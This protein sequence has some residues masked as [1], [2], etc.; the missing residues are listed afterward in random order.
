ME[1]SRRALLG[2]L[3]AAA[4]AGAGLPAQSGRI[5]QAGSAQLTLASSGGIQGLRFDDAELVA[6]GLGDGCPELVI[7]GVRLR[8]DAP[9][10]ERQTATGIA[11]EYRFTQ[12]LPVVVTYD[13]GLRPL[14]G[15]TAVLTQKVSFEV[16]RDYTDRIELRVPRNLRLPAAQRRDFAPTREGV[17]RR[18]EIPERSA[19]A[20]EY[21]MAGDGAADGAPRLG[22][23]LLGEY[24]D[25]TTVRLTACSEPAF[26]TTFRNASASEPG[27]FG[28]THTIGGRRGERIERTF[29]SIVGRLAERDAVLSIYDTA[30]A[31]V[32]PGPTWLRDVTLV[33]YDYLSENGRGW[34]A[35][36]DALC[37]WFPPEARHRVVVT[38]HGWFDFV[39]RYAFDPVRKALDKRWVAF[40]HAAHPDFI[41]HATGPMSKTA[42]FWGW[43]KTLAN[44]R[45]VEMSLDDM[46]RRI[47]YA[48]DRGIRCVLYFGD[49]VNSGDGLT[50]IHD[51]SKVLAWGGWIGPETSGRTYSQNPL[52]PGVRA[53]Y[54]DYLRAILT[55][56][57][58]LDGLV[59]DETFHVKAGQL[60]VDPYPGYA[61]AAMMSLVA[62]LREI[63]ERHNPHMAFLSSD[64]LDRT[65]DAPYA[66]VAHG[67][68][69]DT[70]SNLL[71]WQYGVLP[72]L[73]GTLWSC[74]WYHQSTWDR[75]EKSV[76]TYGLPVAVSNGFGDNLGP[77]EM[78]VEQAQRALKLIRDLGDRSLELTWI[79]ASDAGKTYKGRPVP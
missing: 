61:D 18:S 63:T 58:Q 69:Q 65:H 51:P 75:I 46:R 52:H 74:N 5:R 41:A 60:G 19:S 40:P 32:R 16:Q 72:N 37:Q 62:E 25:A 48:K 27:L 6:S 49:G 43:R 33:H 38:L 15:K 54:T 42:K 59:W 14:S 8:C 36:I 35:D 12:P 55:E 9:A 56:F 13:V 10:S 30:L 34:Y 66:F 23:P 3:G 78:N 17:V 47:K 67:T 76:E 50:G 21:K 28:W 77:S 29:H 64:C 20:Y 26:T 45:P 53:F 22:M 71:D 44:L 2:G 70:M 7:G 57:G 73:R 39:G 31:D 4:L 24:A 11:F 68:Y 1:L 79:E